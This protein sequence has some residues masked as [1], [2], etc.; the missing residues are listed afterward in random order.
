MS[1]EI[2]NENLITDEK[3]TSSETT[4]ENQILLNIVSTEQKIEEILPDID[5]DEIKIQINIFRE[6]INN[7][8][9]QLNTEY[10]TTLSTLA[11]NYL[12]NESLDQSVLNRT[13]SLSMNDNV[14]KRKDA[15]QVEL[16]RINKDE[17]IEEKCSICFCKKDKEE[18]IVELECGHQYHKEC[19]IEWLHYKSNCPVCRKTIKM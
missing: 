7:N 6:S 17:V 9:Q 2:L 8:V 16:K 18:E 19:I 12:M 1:S 14:L 10:L 13:L 11:F 15:I 4:E 5:E 3:E